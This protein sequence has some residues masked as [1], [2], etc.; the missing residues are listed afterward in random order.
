MELKEFPFD[1]QDLTVSLAINCRT[2]GMMPVKLVVSPGA[3]LSLSHNG[4][5]LRQSWRPRLALNVEEMLVGASE[6]RL[7]P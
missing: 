2:V 5:A 3:D 6:D 7:F 1:A 4:F